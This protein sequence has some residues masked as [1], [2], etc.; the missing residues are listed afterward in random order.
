M[1]HLLQNGTGAV[2]HGYAIAQSGWGEIT[3]SGEG[4]FGGGFAGGQIISSGRGSFAF[5]QATDVGGVVQASGNASFALGYDVQATQ[6]RAFAIG[7][8]FTNNT[9]DT[10]QVG[11]SSSP[12]LTVNA[13]NV[14]I[15]T[16]SPYAKLSVV[17]EV[18]ASHFTGTITARCNIETSTKC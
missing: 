8:S 15:G 7:S 17:G 18:V 13:T 6:D 16:S 12:T 9:A 11:F 1:H 4:S 5:G 10:F 3:S 14:G 2:A